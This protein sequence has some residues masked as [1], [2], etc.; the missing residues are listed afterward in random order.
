VG[1]QVL[2]LSW[3]VMFLTHLYAVSGLRG[4]VRPVLLS[5]SWTPPVV[6]IN[7]NLSVGFVN[8]TLLPNV[9]SSFGADSDHGNPR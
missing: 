7:R 3:E 6:F 1:F 5:H 2:G 4:I 8:G 9:L